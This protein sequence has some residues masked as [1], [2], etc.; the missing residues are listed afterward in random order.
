MTGDSKASSRATLKKGG[1]R[2]QLR[3]KRKMLA[4]PLYAGYLHFARQRHLSHSKG[5]GRLAKPV[6]RPLP[7]PVPEV[8]KIQITSEEWLLEVDPMEWETELVAG[9]EVDPAE[10]FTEV[11]EG[12]K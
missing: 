1:E 9:D 4:D 11:R 2:G 6:Y 8:Q 3:Q 7:L 5:N 10:W 12:D